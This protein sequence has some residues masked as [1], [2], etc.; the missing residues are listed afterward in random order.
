MVT[1]PIL[2]PNVFNLTPFEMKVVKSRPCDYR[3]S[4]LAISNQLHLPANAFTLLELVIS[5][6][7]T[8][9]V[10]FAAST[11][12]VSELRV[13]IKFYV[14]QSLRDQM[15]RV[16]F[17]IESEVGESSSF[18]QQAE[19][20]GN[21]VNGDIFLFG[22]RHSYVRAEAAGAA[23]AARTICY[24]NRRVNADQANP[25]FDLYRI[26]PPFDPVTGVL[27]TDADALVLIS[28]GT[29]LLNSNQETGV[30]INNSTA[31]TCTTCDG[32]TL[33]YSISLQHDTAFN[34]TNPRVWNL[35]YRPVDAN[36]NPI[37][38]TNRILSLCVSSNTASGWCSGQ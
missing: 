21:V 5:I 17:L 32:R 6:A 38:F 19:C 8:V 16:T 22:L 7:I 2:M 10:L 18:A 29:Q 3:F 31:T 14:Y 28:P 34:S 15:A 33:S 9:T 35:G 4:R 23:A 13:G 1:R 20:P 27:G 11:I 30:D 12:A 24:F 36:N 25:V 26:G 37:V